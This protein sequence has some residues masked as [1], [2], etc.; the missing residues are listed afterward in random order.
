[1]DNHTPNSSTTANPSATALIGKDTKVGDMVA[2]YPRTINI[3]MSYGLNC[4]GCSAN[5]YE[6]IENGALGHGM[7]QEQVDQLLGELNKV[8]SIPPRP[9][10]NIYFTEKAVAKVKELAVTENKVGQALKVEAKSAGCD[11]W[12]YLMDF[13]PKAEADEKEIEIN[14]LKIYISEASKKSLLGAEI[15]YLVTAQGEGFKIENPNKPECV[16]GKCEL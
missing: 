4:I 12:E 9:K 13:A 14:G 8:A 3:M 2:K 5:P 1:M 11:G 7:T 15:D 16:C 6:T 10:D